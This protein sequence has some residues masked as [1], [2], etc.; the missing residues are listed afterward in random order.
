MSTIGVDAYWQKLLTGV[1]IV[2]II[3]RKKHFI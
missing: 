1:I 2:I 3:Q